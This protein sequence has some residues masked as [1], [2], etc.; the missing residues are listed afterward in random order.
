MKYIFFVLLICLFSCSNK[1]EETKSVS[2]DIA[3]AAGTPANEQ[4]LINDVKQYPDS[5]LVFENLLQYYK[6]GGNTDK[7]LAAINSRQQT[8]SLN[9]RWWD[10]KSQFY[11]EKNDTLRAINSLNKAISIYPEPAYIISLGLL[12]AYAK[13]PLAIEMAD[14][15]IAGSHAKADK[16]AYFIKGLYY[17][18]NNEKQKAIPFFDKSLAIDYQFMDAYSQKALAYYDLQQYENAAKVA[19]KAVLLQNNFAE[20]YFILG[21]SYEKLNRK[22]EA[23]NA[24]RSAILYDPGFAEAQD[25]LSKLGQ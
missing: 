15:L 14:A 12:Y 3:S 18:Y 5:A 11:L 8:D 23:A 25:A 1:Q 4:A 19:E 24:Y 16:E 7:A 10:I 20:G 9:P 2:A 13:N 6:T 22:E 21:E 17:A